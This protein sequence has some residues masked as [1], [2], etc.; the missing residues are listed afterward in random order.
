MCWLFLKKKN[1]KNSDKETESKAQTEMEEN[2]SN[3]RF[4]LDCSKG[5]GVIVKEI[6]QSEGVPCFLLASGNGVRSKL[7]LPLENYKIYVPSELYEKGVKILEDFKEE[8]SLPV[9]ENLLENRDKW[10][11]ASRFALKR[12]KRYAKTNTEEELF[13]YIE[14]NMKTAIVED[15]G[16]ISGAIDGS[17]YILVTTDEV[18]IFFNSISYEIIDVL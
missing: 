16:L 4:L 5:R 18:Q 17:H 3:M 14:K 15:I 10:H 11:I 1:L 2:N 12:A 9:K 7:A 8:A 13:L 6:L